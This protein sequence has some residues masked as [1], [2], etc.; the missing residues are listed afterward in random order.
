MKTLPYTDKVKEKKKKHELYL[1]ERELI[2]NAK[3]DAGI[4]LDKRK[5]KQT[6]KPIH[7][8]VT[9]TYSDFLK[10]KVDVELNTE[11]TNEQLIRHVIGLINLLPVDVKQKMSRELRRQLCKIILTM[12]TEINKNGFLN[13]N[14]PHPSGYG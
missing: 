5:L 14:E 13:F 12:V 9:E 6:T 7:K 1:K 11:Y 8:T 2:R 10:V 4:P 3:I